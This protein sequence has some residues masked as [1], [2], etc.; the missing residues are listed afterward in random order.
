MTQDDEII[1][2]FREI[3]YALKKRIVILAAAMAAGALL[4][5][6]ITQFCM[7]PLYSSTATMLVN[8]K[9]TETSTYSDLQMETQLTKDYSTLVTSRTVLQEVI[10]R[11]DLGISTG[12][13][14]GAITIV[15]PE[16]TRILEITVQYPDPEMAKKIVDELVT[17]SSA[18]IA[19]K[20][21]SDPPKTIEEGVVP[22][23]QSSPSLKKNVAAG[24]A[25][26]LVLA[27]VIIVFPV[28]F[29]DTIKSEDDVEQYL[30]LSTLASIPDR[31]DYISGKGGAGSHK[32]GTNRRG[33]K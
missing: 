6:G 13:L 32:K 18:F 9:E 22:Q 5:G 21:E 14:N 10:D 28:V 33:Q 20:M 11:L 4:A 25:A 7:T 12:A 31:Q 17:V 19:E 23:F 8:P 2:D 15:N 26:C 27:A 16:E 30:G 24:A 1:I 3:F 29:D